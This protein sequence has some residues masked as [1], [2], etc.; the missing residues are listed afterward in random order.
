M[1]AVAAK[2]PIRRAYVFMLE[3]LIKAF[4]LFPDAFARGTGE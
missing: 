4:I 2:E 1:S 3:L